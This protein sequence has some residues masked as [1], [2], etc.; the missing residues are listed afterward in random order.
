[1]KLF[2]IL[3]ATAALTAGSIGLSAPAHAQAGTQF[4]GQISLFGANFCPRGWSNADG[5]LLPISQHTALFSILGTTY[6][7]D[8]RTTF[9]LPDLR[10]RRSVGFGNGP[11]IGSYYMGQK[12]GSTGFTLTL[13]QLPSHNHTGTV[14]ASPTAGDTNQPVRNSFAMAPTGNNI[15][16]DGS[17]AINNMH[18]GTIR[19]VNNGGGQTVNKLSPYQVLRWCVA[20]QGIFPSRS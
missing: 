11:G 2:K 12:G 9:G 1:M 19:I 14:A 16:L 15:F 13:G 18:A 20:L 3:A 4:I 6:G 7:G 10:G 17:P 5:Q 8:G